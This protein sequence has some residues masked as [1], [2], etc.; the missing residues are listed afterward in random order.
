M[1]TRPETDN[2]LQLHFGVSFSSGL[3]YPNHYVEVVFE[4]INFDAIKAPY[5]TEGSEVPC[6]LSS[7]F[8][9]ADGRTNSPHCVVNYVHEGHGTLVVRVV[10][11]GSLAASTS[12]TLSLDDFLLP[13]LSSLQEPSNPFSICLRFQTQSTALHYERCFE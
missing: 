13:D 3:S 5:N 11:I 2:A 12:F 1:T 10:E 9:P 7:D 4:D 6:T 8:V